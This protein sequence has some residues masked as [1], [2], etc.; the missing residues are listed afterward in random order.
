MEKTYIDIST[1]NRLTDEHQRTKLKAVKKQILF[2]V[3]NFLLLRHN[4]HQVRYEKLVFRSFLK[5]E[6][7][8]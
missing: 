4:N 5:Y 8:Y 1:E 2:V 3:T 7:F 6:S